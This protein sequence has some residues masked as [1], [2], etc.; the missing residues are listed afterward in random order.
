M[1][2]LICSLFQVFGL[3]IDNGSTFPLFREMKEIVFFPV[4]DAFALF[5]FGADFFRDVMLGEE[6]FIALALRGEQI[7]WIIS[8]H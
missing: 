1:V 5:K 6:I 8:N 2:F 7:F 4:D 3:A